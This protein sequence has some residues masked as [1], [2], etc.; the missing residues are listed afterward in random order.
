MSLQLRLPI[1]RFREEVTAEQE[2]KE[3][4][5]GAPVPTME[6]PPDLTPVGSP[7]D[8]VH[9]LPSDE[10]HEHD[11]DLDPD[12]DHEHEQ[13]S[14]P[15]VEYYFS[16]EN[17]PTDKYMTSLIKQNKEG[18]VPITV[19]ASFRKM[20]KLTRDHSFIVAA[21]RESSVLVV[22]SDGKKVKRLQPF[23]EVKDPKF[24][25]VLVENLPEDHSV[26]NL[27]RI[28]GAA[29]KIK[30]IS[31]CDPHAVEKSK[32]GSK[33]D[34]L[35]SS[36]LHALVEYE[37]V[38]TAEKAVSTVVA[39]LNNEQDWRNGMRVKLLKQM[40]KQGQRRRVWREPDSEKNCNGRAT[41]QA[42][43]EEKHN[44]SEL[45]D[46][47]PDEKGGEHVSKE[48]NGQ[49]GGNRGRSRKNKY[50][51][52]NGMGHGTTSSAYTVE[53]SK[54][55]PGPKM[56]DGTRGFTMGRGRPPIPNQS[57][58]ILN[59]T[60]ARGRRLDHKIVQVRAF[61]EVTYA[62][63]LSVASQFDDWGNNDG[64]AG[65]MLSSSDGEDSDGEYI[66]NPVTDMDFPAAKVST[67]DALTVT[68][69]RLAMIGR[70]PEN[71]GNELRIHQSIMKEGPLRL[72]KRRASPTM[73]GLFLVPIGVGVAKFLAGFS[74]VEVSG[75]AVAT[76]AFAAIGLIDDILTIIK[77]HNSGLSACMKIF[78]EVAVGTC[79]S[80]WLDS[81]SIS[82]PYSMKM[83]VPLPA[84]LGL[85]CLGKCYSLL[86]SFC[87]VSMGNG[88]D[89]TD[90]LDGLAAGTAALAFV[91]MSIAVLPICSELAI[92]GASMAGAC[93]GFLL[94][95]RYKASVFMGDIGSLAL[96][97]ALAAM[98]ACS[99]MFL[100][101]F[102]SSGI[103]VLEASSVVIQAASLRWI[104]I[105]SMDSF[106]DPIFLFWS[107]KGWSGVKVRGLEPL[108]S[109]LKQVTTNPPNG[110]L[111]LYLK[112]IKRMRGDGRC[113]FQMAPIHHQLELCGLKEPIIVVGAYVIS[114]VLAVFAGYVGLISA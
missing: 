112:T 96:G 25:T 89:L 17:L 50:R 97:G 91:G 23:A 42:R 85:I 13:S 63:D 51:V 54:P 102:I 55:P 113:L 106:V 41:N 67:N 34:I 19:I 6:S 101:L 76:L 43:D 22:N 11:D 16:D 56:P 87:F 15:T 27:Q 66:I 99:G 8:G 35:I 74:S 12:H 109:C 5:G 21:L 18:F 114:G 68:A 3:R 105:L 71:G 94:H 7:E 36:K 58:Q 20:K 4:E 33:V 65:Y 79:F 110:G 32:K 29:G 59:G 28:F 52:T 86:T 26:A 92:F 24:C 39:T 73:G 78:L 62:N 37:T 1:K 93:F 82:S 88:I 57:Q 75:A 60:N 45:H 38:D 70:A 83:L 46:D 103:F 100:P 30:K 107:C 61:D 77:N 10:Y 49:Q 9:A 48:K 95:N 84:P 72:S 108:T 81:T 64:A 2:K 40:V 104:V 44:S 80:F 69:H 98:A 111:V 53:L 31:I 90:G 47:T 14:G